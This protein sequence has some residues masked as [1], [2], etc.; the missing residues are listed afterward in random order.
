[1]HILS[2]VNL[3][4]KKSLVNFNLN[5]FYIQKTGMPPYICEVLT[6]LHHNSMY[7]VLDDVKKSSILKNG[8]GI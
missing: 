8:I 4:A 7:M 2:Y 5:V 1:M 6:E 3:H